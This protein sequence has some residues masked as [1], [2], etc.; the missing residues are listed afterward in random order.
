M[1]CAR[2]RNED[3]DSPHKFYTL[4]THVPVDSF[5]GTLYMFLITVC[6]CMLHAVCTERSE[7]LSGQWWSVCCAS[8]SEITV[9]FVDT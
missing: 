1:R 9:E 5:K 7:V 3:E 8:W 2:K 6:V 4:V